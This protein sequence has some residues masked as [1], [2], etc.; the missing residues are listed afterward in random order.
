[1]AEG[2]IVAA[3]L[4]GNRP[5]TAHPAL[6]VTPA[7]IA[8][9][10]ARCVAAG[11]AIVHVHA[12]NAAGEWTADRAPWRETLR[13]IR[14]AAPDAIVSITSL[15]P[16]G[17]PVTVII[18]LLTGLADDAA[19]RP[20]LISVN[21]GHLAVWERDAAGALRTMHYPNDFADAAALLAHCAAL[22]IQP[23]LGLMNLGFVSNALL[24][25]D[26][27][28]LPARPWCLL[29]LDDPGTVHAGQVIAS[30][31]AHY[32]ALRQRLTEFFPG[33]HPCAHGGDIAGYDV[34]NAGISTG[35]H[36]RVGFEDALRLPDGSQPAGNADLVTWAAARAAAVGRAPL[37]GAAARARIAQGGA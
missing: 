34:I 13:A 17:V 16:A 7:S 5:A 8:T 3:A 6:P 33:V 12:R 21:L 1:M 26:A 32:A 22:G 4:N 24:L 37:L 15:R 36:V 19:T 30:T 18:D 25:R 31:P 14:A 9:E 28:L 11:A 29:E 2:I 23:E 35:D 20:D 10:A 27:G